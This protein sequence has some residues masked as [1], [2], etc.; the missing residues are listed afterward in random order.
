MRSLPPAVFF[1]C[2]V[3][4]EA[5][6]DIA[7]DQTEETSPMAEASEG[8][9]WTDDTAPASSTILQPDFRSLLLFGRESQLLAFQIPPSMSASAQS[10]GS[11]PQ[12]ST[13]SISTAAASFYSWRDNETL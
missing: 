11:V 2:T 3:R 12:A 5:P 9:T 10:G 4:Y 7:L 6:W 1:T 8:M 13:P